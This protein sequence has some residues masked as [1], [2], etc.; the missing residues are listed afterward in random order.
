M[1][2]VEGC[3]VGFVGGVGG[4]GDVGVVGDGPCWAFLSLSKPLDNY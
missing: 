3:D 2:E 1:P 4:V